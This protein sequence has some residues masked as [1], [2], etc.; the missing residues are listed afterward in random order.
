M[1]VM[2]LRHLAVAAVVATTSLLVP[3]VASATVP[4]PFI[5]YS[6]DSYLRTPLAPNAPLAPDSAAGIAYAKANDPKAYPQI[7]GVG[8]NQFGMVYGMGLCTDPVWKIGTV[9]GNSPTRWA[10]LKTTG[11]H[12]P[13]N[14]G[15]FTGT[16]DSPF[17][18]IDTCTGISV[19]GAQAVKGTGNVINVS[20]FGAFNHA[21]NGLDRRN[22]ASNNTQNERSRGVIPDSMVIREDSL[23]AGIANNGDLGQ[24][25]EMFW[26][27]TNSAAGFKNPMVGNESG[28]NGYGA[29]GQRIRIKASVDINARS[30]SPAGKVVARTLQ[31]YGAYLGDNS[32]SGS[33][34]KAQ[35]GSTTLTQTSLSCFTWDDFEFPLN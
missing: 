24:V 21:S 2:K 10:S 19:W 27:E 35:Q 9:S 16:S 11:F 18:V 31:N 20:T 22:P 34:L 4:L 17:V 26:V 15:P 8:G 1:V 6:T 12:A 7:R 13:A 29:E 28:K 32:G 23:A 5:A 14:L 3:A 25:L 33:G 30:C